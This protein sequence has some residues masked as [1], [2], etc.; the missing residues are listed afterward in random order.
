MR[1]R[2]LE[3]EQRLEAAG[4]NKAKQVRDKERDV[5]EKIALGQA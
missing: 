4:K 1:K 5:S 3:A 2:E